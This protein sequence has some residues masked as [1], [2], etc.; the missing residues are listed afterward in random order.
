MCDAKNLERHK[1]YIIFLDEKQEKADFY[2]Q[3]GAAEPVSNVR[4][5]TEICNL[6][7]NYPEGLFCSFLSKIHLESDIKASCTLR[8]LY[9]L[10]L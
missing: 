5:L 2:I 7:M 8:N 4:K 6:E 1:K 3:S 10:L 9:K